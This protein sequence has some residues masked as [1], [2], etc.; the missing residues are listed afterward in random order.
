MKANQES[1]G[2]L[3]GWKCRRSVWRMAGVLSRANRKNVQIA[4][5]GP[6]PVQ[7]PGGLHIEAVQT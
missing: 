4:R 2:W 3:I 1:F 7:F 6:I 5:L